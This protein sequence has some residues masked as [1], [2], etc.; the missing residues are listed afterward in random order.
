MTGMTTTPL[1]KNQAGQPSTNGGHFAA[2]TKS[3]APDGLLAAADGAGHATAKLNVAVEAETAAHA[4]VLEA[5]PEVLRELIL[6]ASPAAATAHFEYFDAYG[7]G[8]SFGFINV[9]DAKGNIIVVTSDLRSA[10]EHITAKTEDA[11]GLSDQP[12]FVG[13]QTSMGGR[14][15]HRLDLTVPPTPVLESALAELE[16]IREA[17]KAIEAR[18]A[19]LRQ[20]VLVGTAAKAFPGATSVVVEDAA[21]GTFSG[22]DI[23]VDR[24]EDAAGKTLWRR[25]LSN[26]VFSEL[27][28]L[29]SELYRNLHELTP[30]E[31]GHSGKS[32]WRVT[33]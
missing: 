13:V 3:E 27:D 6:D 2:T 19:A 28:E 16:A 20:Q 14:V 21:E 7:D 9:R 22:A 10:V 18:I 17:D 1:H 12:A 29:T 33:A 5:M 24:I 31:S 26:P 32:A 4:R 11:G 30:A 23:V 15:L 8:A 25:D